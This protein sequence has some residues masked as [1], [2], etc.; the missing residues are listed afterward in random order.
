VPTAWVATVGHGLWRSDDLETWR[1]EPGV[2]ADA[3]LLSLGAGGDTLVAGGRGAVH[4]CAGGDWTAC[5]LPEAELEAWTL[6]VTAEDPDRVLVGCRPLALFETHNGGRDWD[7]HSIAL[8][9]D[10]PRPH[11]PRVTA[12]LEVDHELWCGVEVGGVFRSED[13]KHWTAANEGLPSLDVHALA[14]ARDG[15]LVAALPCGVARYDGGRWAA[16]ALHAPWAYCRALAVV[17]DALVCGLG[18]G[19]PGRRGGVVV[20]EDDGRSWRS[21]RF[22]G[23]AGSTVWSLSAEGDEVL[24]AAFGG[25][26]FASEDAGRSWRR[27]DRTFGEVRAVLLA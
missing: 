13:G 25:E 19:P 5:A 9:P 17:D 12:M 24:A 27:L 22:P 1:A 10:T 7:A 21:A 2:P 23:T 8:A 15:A 11:T 3:R 18:D 4:R 20:S 16:A 14:R 6:R 26:L